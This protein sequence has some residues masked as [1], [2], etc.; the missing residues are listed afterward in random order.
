[1]VHSRCRL[2]VRAHDSPPV[3]LPS[4]LLDHPHHM[5]AAS[6]GDS[7]GEAAREAAYAAALGCMPS[8]ASHQVLLTLRGKGLGCTLFMYI[9]RLFGCTR[10]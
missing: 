5:A 3:G 8:A 4:G 1:M 2:W 9:L 10:S 6:P 7:P